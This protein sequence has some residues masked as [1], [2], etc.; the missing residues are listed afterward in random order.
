MLFMMHCDFHKGSLVINIFEVPFWEGGGCPKKST[1]LTI[2]KI[3][4]DPESVT[5]RTVN[6]NVNSSQDS[7]P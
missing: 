7:M 3:M 5:R 2:L 1:L 4:D 6:K